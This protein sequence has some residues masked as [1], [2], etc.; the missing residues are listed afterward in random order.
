MNNTNIPRDCGLDTFLNELIRELSGLFGEGYTL[1]PRRQ[2]RNNSTYLTGISVKKDGSDIAPS[3]YINEHYNS[4]RQGAS[5]RSIV[6]NLFETLKNAADKPAIN[7]DT[8]SFDPE[9][10]R[11]DIFFKLINTERN[12]ELLKTVPHREFLDLSVIYCRYIVLEERVLGSV[13]ITND[14]AKDH[15]L[16]EEELF[17]LAVKNTPRL[18]K[19]VIKPITEMLVMLGRKA[20]REVI[21]PDCSEDALPMYVLSNEK[22]IN[23]ASTL[24]YPEFARKISDFLTDEVFVIPSSIHELILIPAVCDPEVILSMVREVNEAEV[25][26]E[27]VLSDNIY[28]Y[29]F[30]TG[31]FSLLEAASVSA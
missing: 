19:P 4:F 24:L 17:S 27:D 18:F 16:T 3:V 10:M 28:R 15:S 8:I 29:S 25:P 13:L 22:Y 11:N 5:L 31:D 6:Y 23:G 2:L 21:L 1:T 9:D 20:A 7:V 30:K 14:F 26:T 12:T